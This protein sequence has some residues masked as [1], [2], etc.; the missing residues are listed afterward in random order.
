MELLILFLDEFDFED[1]GLQYEW[2]K[3]REEYERNKNCE[4]LMDNIAQNLSYIFKGDCP[5]SRCNTIISPN[6]EEIDWSPA[7]W[8]IYLKVSESE[9]GFT[10]RF[11]GNVLAEMEDWLFQKDFEKPLEQPKVE[12]KVWKQKL[13]TYCKTSQ[14]CKRYKEKKPFVTESFKTVIKMI[15]Q[16]NMSVHNKILKKQGITK[17]IYQIKK[18]VQNDNIDF[19]KYTQSFTFK[20]QG[21]DE[22]I[23]DVLEY[24][25]DEL[26]DTP[27][28][29]TSPASDV[30]TLDIVSRKRKRKGAGKYGTANISEL[31][32]AFQALL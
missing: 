26:Y 31:L 23:M 32:L 7:V 2:T 5:S 28:Q 24:L 3:I 6:N 13:D 17:L 25:P 10:G 21:H 4:T 16:V 14:L 1:G 19:R 15:L 8:Y 22:N 12:F 20:F 29:S 18:V 9:D 27:A 11:D 30:N